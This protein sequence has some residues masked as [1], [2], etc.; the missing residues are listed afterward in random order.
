MVSLELVKTVTKLKTT[1]WNGDPIRNPGIYSGLPLEDYHA[2]ICIEPSVSSSGLRTIYD[3]SPAHY[4]VSSPYNEH[5][6]TRDP[7]EH[8]TV[9]SLVNTPMIVRGTT[10]N[11][12]AEQLKI[13]RAHV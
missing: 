2:D 5:A 9:G 11:A 1:V 13:G 12:M 7:V 3:Q 8:F 10:R 6:I 4:W